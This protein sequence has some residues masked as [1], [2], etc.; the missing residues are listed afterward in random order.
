MS[1]AFQ[2]EMFKLFDQSVKQTCDAIKL[3]SA[4]GKLLLLYSKSTFEH[5]VPNAKSHKMYLEHL[6]AGDKHDTYIYTYTEHIFI[7]HFKGAKKNEDKVVYM[8]KWKDG[9]KNETISSE[10]AKRKWP[11][12]LLEFLKSKISFVK[13]AAGDEA[14][15]QGVRFEEK[16]NEHATGS[17]VEIRCAY[18]IQ[19]DICSML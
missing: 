11:H 5:Y 17:P 16:Q 9:W 19:E 3:T 7:L 15:R 10:E 1:L 6:F 13:L 2:P 14:K 8:M 4:F 18:N 12:M